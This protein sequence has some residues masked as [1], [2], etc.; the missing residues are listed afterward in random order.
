VE[1]RLCGN[2]LVCVRAVVERAKR[3]TKTETC[4]LVGTAAATK[5]SSKEGYIFR[6]ARHHA[7]LLGADATS[8]QDDKRT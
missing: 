1:L 5:I 6:I 7:R 2:E 8:S 3:L 4:Y